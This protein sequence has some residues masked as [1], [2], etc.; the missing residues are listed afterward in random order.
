LGFSPAE[1][2]R[3]IASI[4]EQTT[5]AVRAQR[6][7]AVDIVEDAQSRGM[8]PPFSPDGRQF[9]EAEQVRYTYTF[10]VKK[11]VHGLALTAD[12]LAQSADMDLE[13]TQSL[14]DAFTTPFGSVRGVHFFAA[15]PDIM[16]RPFVKRDDD[17][18]L[19]SSANL[20]WAL[21][22][23]FEKALENDAAG[24]R[25]LA[26]RAAAVE[27]WAAD[28]LK[29]AFGP[30]T[31]AWTNLKFDIDGAGGY[32]VDVLIRCDHL[33][34]IG[35]A[36]SGMVRPGHLRRDLKATVGKASRQT[37]RLRDALAGG[38]DVEFYENTGGDRVSV[39]VDLADV[40][41]F[42]AVVVTL[43]DAMF[44]NGREAELRAAG[45]IAQN[46]YMPWVVSLWD[47]TEICNLI[48]HPAQLSLYMKKRRGIDDTLNG[49]FDELDL[50]MCHLRYSLN[51][52]TPEGMT[53][54]LDT[55]FTHELDQ[56]RSLGAGPKPRQDLPEMTEQALAALEDERKPGFLAEA[57]ELIADVQL[58]RRPPAH[59]VDPRTTL[60][61]IA[62]R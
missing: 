50:F 51:M 7:E 49:M 48:E 17:Y 61:R 57:E 53:G 32:E 30:S 15:E 35:E 12:R 8:L 42:E 26:H 10:L 22:P 11:L 6:D 62:G 60:A 38:Q 1:A 34:I 9:G 47:L 19:T 31:Q 52:S 24:A 25:Y 29:S 27:Q 28:A 43:D 41:R 55:T 36:K 18:L 59:R 20:L 3:L 21:R 5:S 37:Q 2:L 56:Y 4:E 14:L 23:A 44:L 58:R 33:C 16:R 39:R 45:V 54:N 46:G 13:T 40:S